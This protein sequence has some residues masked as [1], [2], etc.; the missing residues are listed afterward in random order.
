MVNKK[1]LR[2]ETLIMD[3][4]SEDCREEGGT[5]DEVKMELF[6]SVLH[7]WME[8]AAMDFAHEIDIDYTPVFFYGG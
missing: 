8:N 5:Y 3:M 7:E 2:F 4:L 1:Q 6:M